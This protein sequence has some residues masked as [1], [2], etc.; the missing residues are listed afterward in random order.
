MRDCIADGANVIIATSSGYM[1]VCEKLA[2]QFPLV[3]FLQAMGYKHNNQNFTFCTTKLYHARYLSGIVAGYKTKTNMIGYVAALGKENSEV[4]AGIDAFAIG[5]EEVN[6]AAR[7]YVWVTYNWYDPMGETDA[8]NA[9]IAAGCDVIA[10]HSNTS[11]AQIAA[12]RAGVWAIGFNTDMSAN[13]PDAVITSVV[14]SW[15]VIYTRLVE[16]IINGTFREAPH[17]YGLAEGAV[18]ITA[19][20]EK[21][22]S[23]ETQAAVEAARRRIIHDGFNVFDGVLETNDGKTV[24]EAGKTLSDDTILGSINWYYRNVSRLEAS[25][26]N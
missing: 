17:F 20:N 25:Q 16:S 21:F 5:V 4:T 19:I 6:P 26:E 10:A 23:S 14:P 8:A 24:G 13:A 12:Q 15:G 2:A 9:L 1:D 7:I 18:D 3:V 22:V 11:N